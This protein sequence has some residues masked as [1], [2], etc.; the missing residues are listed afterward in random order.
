MKDKKDVKLLS[1]AKKLQGL[2]TI[3]TIC[4]KLDIREK[5]AINYVH[6]MRMMGLVKTAR[7][8]NKV[9]IYNISP[10]KKTESGYPGMYD[11]INMYSPMKIAE[12]F[13]HRVYE[14]MGIEEAITRALETKDFRIILSSIA[15]FRHVKDWSKLYEYAKRSG[16]RRKVGALYDLSRQIMKVRRIDKRIER[17]LLEAKQEDAFIVPK[18]RTRDFPS[19]EKKWKVHIPFTKG[20]LRRLKE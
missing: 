8:K 6:E 14:K 5:T 1:M 3:S 13:E 18:I 17:R 19:I 7:G 11:I 15:L 20:D 16:N 2:N 12:P 4:R 9:R 10:V